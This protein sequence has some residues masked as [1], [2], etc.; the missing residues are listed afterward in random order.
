MAPSVQPARVR[1]RRGLAVLVLCV[2]AGIGLVG[3]ILAARSAG[4]MQP[5]IVRD[6]GADGPAG[7]VSLAYASDGEATASSD[8]P[9]GWRREW[10][11]CRRGDC[12]T[13]LGT[14]AAVT[15]SMRPGDRI[16]VWAIG[17]DEIHV[18]STPRWVGRVRAV[19]RP[20]LRGAPKIGATL[21][22]EPGRYAGGFEGSGDGTG[23]YVGIRACPTRAGTGCFL[24][25]D[26]RQRSG[27][28]GTLTAAYAG[29]FVGAIHLLK[30][31]FSEETADAWAIP[32]RPRDGRPAPDP[33]V[34]IATSP[35]V[36]PVS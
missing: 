31:P 3:G 9:R 30:G 24:I 5:T 36:G 27:R 10:R 1:R 16:E 15:T 32:R 7:I 25:G 14:D 35:L 8:I 4:L 23:G 2:A 12:H 21:R 6:H 18:A 34:L 20:T 11:R 28:A 19:R 17:K 26:W 22:A 13:R 29:W 33:G